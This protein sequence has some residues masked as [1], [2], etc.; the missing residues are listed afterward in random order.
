VYR[1]NTVIL[2]S[3]RMTLRNHV[4][5]KLMRYDVE[6]HVIFKSIVSG[7]PSCQRNVEYKYA[8]CPLWYDRFPNLNSGQL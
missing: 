6:I 4:M 7:N 1:Y 3:T 2:I 8:L 5:E